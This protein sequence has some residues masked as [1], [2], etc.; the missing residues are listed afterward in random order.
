M[1]EPVHK[2][3]PIEKGIPLH[4]WTCTRRSHAF[5]EL[6]K[7]MRPGDSVKFGE[8]EEAQAFACQGHRYGYEMATRKNGIEGLGG[9]YRVWLVKAPTNGHVLKKR[10]WK[11]Q[12][13]TRG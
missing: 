7:K 1:S 10:K 2:M 3:P 12:R 6:M 9:S 8:R 5:R 13:N 11:Q 4:P